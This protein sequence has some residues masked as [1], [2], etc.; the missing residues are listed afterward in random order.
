MRF[1][2]RNG[3]VSLLHCGIV[4]ALGLS[5]V[6]ACNDDYQ[7]YVQ[8]LDRADSAVD[9]SD[10]GV[11]PS[12]DVA[13]TDTEDII[14]TEDV[15]AN[16]GTSADQDISGPTDV[17]SEEVNTEDT[18]EPLEDA[19]ADGDDSGTDGGSDTAADSTVDGGGGGACQ[20]QV[21]DDKN[22]CTADSCD[23][24]TAI[25]MFK[26]FDG[27]CDDG[28]P[29][30]VGETC[31]ESGMCVGPPKSCDDNNACTLDTCDKIAGCGS[32]DSPLECQDG[33]E[34]TTFDY[35]WK[36]QC[37]P[38]GGCNGLKPGCDSDGDKFCD[39]G[40]SCGSK[41]SPLRGRWTFSENSSGER[42]GNWLGLSFLG[43]IPSNS[44]MTVS[45]G[46]NWG[47]ADVYQG[48]DIGAKTLVAWV[49]LV[50]LSVTPGSV[51]TLDAV[52]DDVYDGI[53]WGQT[54]NHWTNGSNGSVRTQTPS[55]GFTEK[56]TGQMVQIAISYA[57]VKDGQAQM[58]LCRNGVQIGQYTKGPLATWKAGNAQVV[59]GAINSSVSGKP[60]G[61]LS[62]HIKE[63]R[64][65]AGAM[66]CVEIGNLGLNC[67][68]N[69]PA[70]LN[71][72]LDLNGNGKG[73]VCE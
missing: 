33:D 29:C 1:N 72:Q 71:N 13:V 58:T 59:F 16:E 35:C 6:A 46:S 2:R 17:A 67:A 10:M 53:V 3:L 25:C 42:T 23:I 18:A 34:C 38:G 66:N 5:M 60:V 19:Q 49:R 70:L 44:G 14:A 73:D 41:T 43:A 11:Q 27:P 50:D 22:T 55:P 32:V 40:I 30:T 26:P 24:E 12:V 57:V 65:Y 62:A 4:W 21:C 31:M 47:Q 63:A 51:L 69:C 7:E 45:K 15:N 9:A 8:I 54:A 68:D 39:K 37:Q 28:D 36:G 61:E 52:T 56:F 20:G 64:I 48:A